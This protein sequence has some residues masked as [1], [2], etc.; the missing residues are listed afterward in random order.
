MRNAPANSSINNVQALIVILQMSD[1]PAKFY[2]V[3]LRVAQAALPEGVTMNVMEH[4][5]EHAE[6]RYVPDNDLKKMKEDLEEMGGP[7]KLKKRK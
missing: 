6:I 7:R 4:Q 1:V 5:P 3:L 2:P